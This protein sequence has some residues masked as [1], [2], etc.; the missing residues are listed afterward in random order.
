MKAVDALKEKV[1]DALDGE[2]V[3]NIRDQAALKIRADPRILE[4]WMGYCGADKPEDI[5]YSDP[6][7]FI[8]WC[9][10][11]ITVLSMADDADAFIEET[12]CDRE[13]FLR[14]YWPKGP[15]P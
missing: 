7:V 5:D 6:C 10:A 2:T 14:Y 3:Q 12:G 1:M 9:A 15:D 13:T 11:D 8:E 4:R